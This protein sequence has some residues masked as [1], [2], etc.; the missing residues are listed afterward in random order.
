MYFGP[1][2]EAR[3]L[4]SQQHARAAK[5]RFDTRS[6]LQAPAAS[7]LV[8]FDSGGQPG[9]RSAWLD[10][11][12]NRRSANFFANTLATLD[13][14]YLRPRYPGYLEFQD[15]ASVMMY[16]FVSGAAGPHETLAGMNRLYQKTFTDYATA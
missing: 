2:S 4:P 15:A 11:E 16:S 1:R 7:G 10:S 3:G 5:R 9:H 12:V 14:A 8:Y 6:T 13:A